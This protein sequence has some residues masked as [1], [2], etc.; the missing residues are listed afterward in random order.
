[1]NTG[2]P[3]PNT[4]QK[5]LDLLTKNPGLYLSK[6][7]ELLDMKIS[8]VEYYLLYMESNKQIYSIKNQG[9][10][11][12]YIEKKRK[13]GLQEKRVSDIRE[14]ILDLIEK[15]PGL[16]LSK[17]AESMDM[18]VSHIEYHLK[19]L[20][21]QNLIHAVRERG[22]FKRYYLK[23]SH[24]DEHEKQIISL[25]RQEIT[26][27][28]VLFLLKNQIAK[29]KDLQHHLGMSAPRVSYHLTKL[30]DHGLIETPNPTSKGYTLKN[31]K[32]IIHFLRKYK[33]HTVIDTFKDI[34]ATLDYY[35]RA[36]NITGGKPP[37]M[38]FKK[39]PLQSS[40]F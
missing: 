19:Y 3:D 20:E 37:L 13:K 18:R 26:L 17:I 21:K 35:D 12:Y 40:L 27:K 32:E 25:L 14:N 5:I 16:H 23:E 6:I 2:L 10:E 28:I 36:G 38:F 11:Q 33:L 8:L 29:Y 22:Y 9:V 1:M 7:A 31:P 39:T 24:V 30:V 15:Q 4:I 34:W